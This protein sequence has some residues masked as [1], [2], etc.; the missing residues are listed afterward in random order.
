[1]LRAVRNF[2]EQRGVLEVETPLLSAAT[3]TDP[4][5]DPLAVNIVAAG[6]RRYLQTSPEYA[7]KRLLA[8]GSGP[9]Y[10]VCKAFRGGEQGRRHNPEFTLLEWYRPGFTLHDLIVEMV[11]LLL[12]L[13]FGPGWQC[14]TYQALFQQYLQLDPHQAP[15]GSLKQAARERIDT[16]FDSDSRDDWLELLMS[17]CIEPQLDP[18]EL[19]F[20][21]DY[22]AS[23]AALAQTEQTPV[24]AVAR[25][26]ELYSGG[27]ELANGYSELRDADELERRFE[28]DR[29]V[30]ADK[31]LEE[32]PADPMLL[33]AMRAGL[34]QCSGVALGLDRVLMVLAAS[35]DISDQLSFDWERA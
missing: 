17:H 4:G 16:G 28:A 8:A 5:I 13:G 35:T 14:V 1:M 24:G 11:E 19:T 12:G 30:L 34:P 6:T 23:Q 27:L 9:I 3:V 7:M 20:V 2:F 18:S 25:R 26:F 22:P 33:L 15:L 31:G 32:R 10:Q 21:L 29:Q